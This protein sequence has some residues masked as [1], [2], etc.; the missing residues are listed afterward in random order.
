VSLEQD[1]QRRD[2]SINAM[3]RE[4]ADVSGG[5]AAGL[6]AVIDPYGGR[7]D[8]EQRRLRHVSPAFVED[9]VRV[10]R[11][12]RFAAR[13][14]S[15]GF[16]VAPETRSLMHS[17][18]ANGEIAALVPERVW[19]EME[20]ALGEPTP[21]AFF[22]TLAS[23]GALG[24]VLPELRWESEDREA[25]RMAAGI[26]DDASV[27][28]AA[29]MAGSGA[30]DL[31]ALCRRLRV[32]GR[33]SELALLCARLRQ[34]LAQAAKL[35]ATDLLDLLDEADALRRPERFE[36]LLQSAAARGAEATSLARLRAAVIA[37][38]SVALPPERMRALDGAEIAA[39]LRVARVE[40]LAS[41]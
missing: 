23:C 24:I 40:R 25:L 32:S 12:A 28:F 37:A 18:A 15:L 6:G 11:V 41:V 33:F 5:G 21:D 3:A 16:T 36:R 8:L 31:D 9:P 22:D 13:F 2:L 4:A 26:S 19:R 35:D 34:R 27:R 39:A 30:E 20:R 7:A 17:M 14:A 10:L 38:A 29:L 1:L